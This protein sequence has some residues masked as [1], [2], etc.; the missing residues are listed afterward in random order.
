MSVVHLLGGQLLASGRLQSTEDAAGPCGVLALYFSA[1]WCGPCRSFT[2]QLK[3]LYTRTRSRLGPAGLQVVFVSRD[4]TEREFAAYAG[5]MPWPS[6]PLQDKTRIEALCVRFAVSSIPSLVFLDAS[7][8]AVLEARG[9][10]RVLSQPAG[11][12]LDGWVGA[13]KP[14]PGLLDGARFSDSSGTEVGLLPTPFAQ[15][16]A[17]YVC[18]DWSAPCRGFTPQL[19][20]W[21]A[22]HAGRAGVQLVL[23]G[24]DDGTCA[25]K[26]YAKMPTGVLS[27]HSPALAEGLLAL[28]GQHTPPVLVV[29]G[30]DNGQLVTADGV[31]LLVEDPT[32]FPWNATKR[33]QALLSSG[34]VLVGGRWVSSERLLSL[35]AVL[36]LCPTPGGGLPKGA[37]GLEEWYRSERRDASQEAVEVWTGAAPDAR[38]P[39]P[40]LSASTK[41]AEIADALGGPGLYVLA[42]DRVSRVALGQAI[43]DVLASR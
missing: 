7:T 36:L 21:Y 8:G 5:G 4:R 23:C 26:E 27:A 15:F 6:V 13:Q 16:H 17:F 24:I 42:G 39:W 29:L 34:T 10:Q 41:R 38:A 3:A 33:V 12:F 35:E 31:R 18:A 20:A 43:R 11:G 37:E 32:G 9:V 25:G 30:A 28:A 22:A 14:V 1:H 40:H 19:A 2:P